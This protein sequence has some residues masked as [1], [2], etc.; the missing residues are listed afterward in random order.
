MYPTRIA[1]A[2]VRTLIRSPF[3]VAQVKKREPIFNDRG[4]ALDPDCQ[5]LLKVVNHSWFKPERGSITRARRLM[6]VSTAFAGPPVTACTVEKRELP[7]P[8][9]VMIPVRVFRP[10]GLRQRVPVIVYYHG[11]GFSMGN[12][13][14]YTRFCQLLTTRCRAVV[15]SVDYRLAPEHPFPA[16]VDDAVA[17]FHWVQVHAAQFGG[18]PRKVAV[19]GDSAGGNLAAVV[20]L[21]ARDSGVRPPC[22]QLLIYPVVDQTGRELSR[23]SLGQGFLLTQSMIEL[24]A[25]CYIPDGVD[26]RQPRVSPLF[27]D[28]HRHLAPAIVVTAGFDPLRD[29]GERYHQTLVDAGVRSKLLAFDRLIHGFINFDGVVRRAAAAAEEITDTFA[30]LL[31]QTPASG[32]PN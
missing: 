21:V 3:R 14:I 15:V 28:D 31:A 7:G 8:D 32:S 19:G 26:L 1:G 13:R 17:A 23:I 25:R 20:G 30:E 10:E 27:A 24:F 12:S 11:G 6:E 2:A 29:E 5:A 9:G 18:D 22:A 4:A 16:A